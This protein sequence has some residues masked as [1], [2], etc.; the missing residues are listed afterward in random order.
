[1]EKIE[2]ENVSLAFQVQSLVRERENIKLEYN[3]LFD[4]IKKTRIQTQGEINELIMNV[5]QKTYTY[6]DVRAKNQDL[7]ITISEL[8]AKLKNAEKV[9]L[10]TLHTKKK[11]VDTNT[12]VIAPGM[13]KVNTAN[14][15][16]TK[17]VLTSIGLEDATS[18]RRPSSRGSSSKNSVLLNTKNHSKDVEVHVMTNKK[19]YVASKKNVVQNK[20]IVTNVNVK[21]ALKIKDVLCV[22]CD[23]NVLTP[24]HFKCLAKYKFNVHS[25]VKRVLF[26]TL[27]TA[28]PKSLDTTLIVA[29]NRFV[30]V[31]PLSAK[32]KDSTAFRSP[33]LFAQKLSLSKYMRTKIKTSMK[34]QKWYETQPNVGWS[35]KRLTANAKP[36]VVK[37]RDHVVSYSNSSVL[38]RK[39]VVKLS[40]PLSVFSSCNIVRFGNDY[41]AAITGYGDYEHG[42]ITIF[43]VYYVEGLG[44]N[45]FSVGKF[46][47]DVEASSPV[48]LM[49][50]ATSTKSWLWHLRLS[51]LNFGTINDLT[52]QDLVYELPKFK[53][54]KDHLCSACERGK[55]KK[56]THPPKLVPSTHL[57]IEL[58]HMDLCGPMRAHYE[59]LGIIQ[60]FSIAR[61]P[62][63][64]GV[65]ERRNRT[66]VKAARIVLIFSKSLEFLWA[67]AIS[68]ACFTQN[69]SL[70]HKR[71]NKTPYELLRGRKPNV[72]YFYVF[73]SLCYP[74]NDREDLGKIKPK[75]YIGIFIGYL[76]SSK[77][78]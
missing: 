41:F 23:K 2:N 30:V 33:S 21:N 48:C 31:N 14:K 51:H 43:H 54:D 12:N 37:R 57:K 36:N 3:K 78:F 73:R 15:Q 29:K 26:T 42:N 67:E 76:E 28:K 71:Y 6:G 50:K 25:K 7:L 18:V 8:K 68:T 74:T 35:P 9:T 65:V 44:H 1:M 34:W 22:S 53:Y 11:H 19:T 52:K 39:W 58:I 5:N 77:G 17:S 27:T 49:S 40:T 72:E 4:S 20:K 46:C 62:Q 56:A 47:D 38:I 32:N 16:E 55:S 69:R 13:Y 63:Q 10:Q 70:I 24:S 75:A 66:L 45:L 59:K 61:T 64:N 60:Q